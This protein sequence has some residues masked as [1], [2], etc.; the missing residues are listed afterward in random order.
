MAVV[1]GGGEGGV[2]KAGGEKRRRGS[3]RGW[4]KACGR[5]NMG[6]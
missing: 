5:E 4:E 2:L 6:V 1:E 3:G